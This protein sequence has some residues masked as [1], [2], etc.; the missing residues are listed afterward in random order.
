MTMLPEVQQAALLLPIDPA[1]VEDDDILA[2]TGDHLVPRVTVGPNPL[3]SFADGAATVRLVL[4][5]SEAGAPTRVDLIDVGGRL[6]R[7][8][9]AGF[10]SAGNH[11][12]TWDGR[13]AMGRPLASV[14]LTSCG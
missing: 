13:D 1:A 5:A 12:L 4:S 7:R 10:L 14:V 3:P 11:V 2:D 9:H 8:I 6:I